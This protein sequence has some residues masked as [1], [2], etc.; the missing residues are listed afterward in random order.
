MA[1]K[2]FVQEQKQLIIH[3][4]GMI[5]STAKQLFESREFNRIVALYVKK[6]VKHS[7][8]VQDIRDRGLFKKSDGLYITELLRMLAEHPLDE[9]AKL[10]PDAQELLDPQSRK[11]LLIFV[12]ELYNF[13]RTFDRFMILYSEPGPSSFDQRPYRSFNA[14]MGTL[15]N[16][17]RGVYRDICEN[18]TGDHPRIYR[19]V[20]A[21]CNVGLI[22]VPRSYTM[23]D[24][25]STLLGGVSF[26]R[27]VL[28][29]P[30]MIIDPPMNKREGQF[31]RITRNPIAGLAFDRDSWLCYPAQV[32]PLVIFIYF[33]QRYMSLGCSLAN[34]F[35]I[36]TDEQIAKGPDA[37]YAYGVPP[38]SLKEYGKLPTV[39]Y[40]DE[41]NGILVGAIPREDHFAYF[42]YLKKMVLTLHNIIMMKRG[43]MPFHGA[44]VH[45]L[46]SSGISANVLLIGDTGTG[47]SETLEA[48]RVLGDEYINE[49]RIIADDMG[50]LEIDEQQRVVRGYGTEVGAFVRLD[51]LQEGFAFGQIDRAII[52]SPQKVNA[53]VVLPVTR[54]EEIIHGYPVDIILYANNYEEV[55]EDH[56]LLEKFST[57]EQALRVYREGTAM[58]KGTTTSTG[59]VHSYFANIFG[60]PQY[61]EIHEHLAEKTFAMAFAS[62]LYV[63]QMRTRLGISGYE[64]KGPQEAAKALF[65]LISELNKANG[66]SC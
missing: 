1:L 49:L 16:L 42:G 38:E 28:I 24:E 43:K 5:C 44:M 61:R 36:A 8:Y 2:R 4:E 46:L 33:H 51:D 3:T 50:S 41:A 45:I 60:P 27:Q 19:Q 20:P 54:L 40:D 39:F 65:A 30:P 57:A 59:I 58:S 23:P 32:G 12:E 18:I 29:N 9:V 53:R 52:M 62:G 11:S 56:P 22:A 64:M 35:E 37:I 7:S 17:I 66:K 15:T 14:T 34:L 63:G 47:K 25:Y 31:T 21:G 10:Q 48:L 13:W 55:D 6:F 26:I